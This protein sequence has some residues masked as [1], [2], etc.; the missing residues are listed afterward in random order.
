M[1]TE[2]WWVLITRLRRLS[3][4]IKLALPK[5]CDT[6]R[7]YLLAVMRQRE[8]KRS[9]DKRAHPLQRIRPAGESRSVL[10]IFFFK[11]NNGKGKQ[12]LTAVM[13]VTE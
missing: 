10:Y 4:Y 13:K 8:E 12:K 6:I 9:Q 5:I 1:Y 11:V 7:N 2:H 3:L